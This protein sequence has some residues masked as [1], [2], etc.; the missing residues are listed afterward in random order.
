MRDAHEWGGRQPEPVGLWWFDGRSL[1]RHTH[2]SAAR[3]GVPVTDG[4]ALNPV[5][6]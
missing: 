1:L 3:C 2:I 4:L 6:Y 5:G